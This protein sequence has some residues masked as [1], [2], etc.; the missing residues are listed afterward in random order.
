MTG[1]VLAV[2]GGNSK[3]EL[4]IA[5]ADGTVLA[6]TRGPASNPHLTGVDGAI[7]VM[8]PLYEQA[9]MMAGLSTPPGHAVYALAGADLPP[10]GVRLEAALGA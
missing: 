5:H 8:R 6:L 4:A 3:T 2:D 10:E 1:M 9:M 7:A